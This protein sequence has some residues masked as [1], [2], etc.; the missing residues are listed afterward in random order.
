MAYGLLRYTLLPFFRWRVSK[1]KGAKKLPADKG[2]IIVANHRSWIDAAVIVSTLY[3]LIGCK[4]YFIASTGKYKSVGGLPIDAK[5]K[6][7]VLEVALGLLN[8]GEVVGVFPSGQASDNGVEEGKTGAA[9]LALWSGVPVV[10]IGIL[11]TS[12][13]TPGSAV[14]NYIKSKVEVVIGRP[15]HFPITERLEIDKKLLDRTTVTIMDSIN[16]LVTKG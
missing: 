11:G 10:P 15:F 12:G 1:V 14:A 2:C 16:N 4:I 7:S 6:D 3:Q 13:K 8:N 9:R 5:D